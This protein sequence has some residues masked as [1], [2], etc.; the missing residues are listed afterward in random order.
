MLAL[1]SHVFSILKVFIVGSLTAELSLPSSQRR[2]LSFDSVQPER[3]HVKAD[4]VDGTP[5]LFEDVEVEL[6]MKLVVGKREEPKRAHF[7]EL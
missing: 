3:E 7:L 2:L 5:M 1:P 6:H 4:M